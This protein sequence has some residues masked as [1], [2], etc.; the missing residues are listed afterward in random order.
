MTKDQILSFIWGL[1]LVV[2]FKMIV[3]DNRVMTIK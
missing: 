2:L 1:T 3:L